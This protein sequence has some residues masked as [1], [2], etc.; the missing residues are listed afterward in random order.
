MSL[1]KASG[2]LAW[3]RGVGWPSLILGANGGADREQKARS[4]T[5]LRG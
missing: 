5:D 3:F 1:A 4:L 2:L